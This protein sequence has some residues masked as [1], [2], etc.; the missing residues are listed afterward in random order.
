MV[1]SAPAGSGL[2]MGL[3]PGALP[4]DQAS[5]Q[6]LKT[7]AMDFPPGHCHA[8]CCMGWSLFPSDQS[9]AT[10]TKPQAPEPCAHGKVRRDRILL[11]RHGPSAENLPGPSRL[12]RRGGRGALACGGAE[13]VGF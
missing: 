2:P 5:R 13:G 1:S 12:L 11:L 8:A 10:P 4:S 6:T 3:M 9:R 7:T